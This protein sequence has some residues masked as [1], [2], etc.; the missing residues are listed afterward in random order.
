MKSSMI[1]RGGTE[2][3]FNFILSFGEIQILG[4]MG[5]H[6]NPSPSKSTF[7]YGGRKAMLKVH[8]MLLHKIV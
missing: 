4:E 8:G 6:I 2:E 1:I 7:F 3:V 5:T